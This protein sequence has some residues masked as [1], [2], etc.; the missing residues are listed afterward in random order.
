MTNSDDNTPTDDEDFVRLMASS[1]RDLRAFIL[2]LVPRRV[3]ADDLLQEVYL[4]LWRKRRLYHQNENFMRWAFGFAALEVRR[5]H[6]RAAKGRLWFSDAA[7]ESLAGAWPQASSFMDDCHQALAACLKKLGGVERQVI[8][9]KYA[10][11]LSVKDIATSTGRPMSTV[12]RIL[13]RG[14][15]S[16]RVCVKRF[17]M[18][19]NR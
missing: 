19:A 15:E 17:Q 8:E 12:Y 4:D 5:F 13:N 11:R 9:A 6:S 14:R 10:T 18:D 16:L 3:D 2:G 7:V 1:Q